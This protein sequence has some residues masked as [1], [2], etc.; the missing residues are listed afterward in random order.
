MNEAARFSI[1]DHNCKHDLARKE[2]SDAEILKTYSTGLLAVCLEGSAP[3]SMFMLLSLFCSYAPGVVI[4]PLV[5][6]FS[7][8]SDRS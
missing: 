2:A 4:H 8:S 1:E 6:L 7:S 5:L 3:I